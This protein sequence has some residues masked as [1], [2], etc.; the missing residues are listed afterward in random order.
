MSRGPDVTV[1]VV[2]YNGGDL[3]PACLETIPPAAETIVVDNG[4]RDGSPETIAARFPS[5]RLLRHSVNRGFAAAV[6]RALE[7]ARGRYVCLLNND[8]RLAPGALEELVRFMDTHPDVGICAPQLLH[9]DG[10]RQHSFDN[11]PSLA[12]VFLNKSLL[13]RLFPGRFPSKHREIAA[14]LDVESVIGA[15]MLVRRDLI[16][17]IGPLDEAYFLFLEETDWCL[18]ARRAGARVVFVPSARVVHLQ[19]R[20]RDRV[21]IRARIE[22]TRSLF[23][24]FRKNRPAAYPVLRALFPVRTLFELLGQTLTLWAPGVPQR[25]I[26]T[27]AVLGWQLCGGPRGW[28]LSGE[29]EPRTATLRDGTRADEEHLEAFHDFERK[30][31]GARVVKDLRRKRTVEYSWGGRTYLVK[32]YKP[33]SALRRLKGAVLGSKAARELA[34]SREVVR[35]GIPC[36][37]VAAARD[38]GPAPWV[39]FQ[40]LEGWAQLQEVLLSDAT[41]PAERRRL[42]RAYGRFARRLHDAG[43]TQYDFNPTNVLVREGRFRLIDFEHLK[44]YGG[45]VPER[46]RWKALAKMNR[47]PR[48]SRT[49][50]LRFLRGYLDAE[51]VD[52]ARLRRIVEA[53]RAGAARQRER[54][55]AR[56][57]RRCVQENRDFGAF[58]LGAVRGYYRKDRGSGPGL[59]PD[60]LRALAEGRVAEGRY[61]LE[62]AADP[63]GEWRRANRRAR[64]GRGPVPAAVLLRDGESRGTLV[65]FPDGTG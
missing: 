5:V 36:V 38:R 22:Y 52:R 28:G 16:E 31:A 1:V 42:C 50:R 39:A 45:R 61:R 9:E 10:R 49:D 37:P 60:D 56:A 24:F 4:S 13:R 23:T 26:E 63:L 3:T 47:I 59:G 20:T 7:E 14:P 57:E 41:V 43:I 25:W 44:I 54:D 34:R 53:I 27:A 58:R 33:G 21:R 30:S 15:C 32:F 55:L 17:R 18:R 46:A 19:G 11:F 65:F 51:E 6:N 8:A 35:R 12:T 64:E 40:K 29:A 62:E 2:N 48:L